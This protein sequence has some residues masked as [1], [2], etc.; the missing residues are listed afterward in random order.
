MIIFDF[1]KTLYNPISKELFEG[2]KEI[3]NLLK[4]DFILILI[5][6]NKEMRDKLAKNL[7]GEFFNEMVFTKEKT[8]LNYESILKKYNIKNSDCTIIGDCLSD[9]I[10]IGKQLFCKT[11][12]INPNKCKTFA[13]F[14]I[15][16]IKEIKTF[17]NHQI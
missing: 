6:M 3:L 15:P 12:H 4:S 16:H 5:S 2:V 8:I 14:S 13:D 7:I 17:I 11:I 9:E 1:N 10:L